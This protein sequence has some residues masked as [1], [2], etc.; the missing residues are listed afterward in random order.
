MNPLLT[1]LYAQGQTPQ[2]KA[3]A[4]G[5]PQPPVVNTD[6]VAW[7]NTWVM[8]NLWAVV[9]I[10]LAAISI[11]M[12]FRWKKTSFGQVLITI[13]MVAGILMIPAVGVF[14]TPERGSAILEALVNL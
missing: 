10:C 6:G 1:A 11:V 9:P 12:L 4:G 2:P 14:M 3:P 13:A 8:T 7:N 5:V